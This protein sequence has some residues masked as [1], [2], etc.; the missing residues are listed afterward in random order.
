MGAIYLAEAF[1]PVPGKDPRGPGGRVSVPAPVDPETPTAPWWYDRIARQ[2]KSLADTGFTAVLLP[3]APKTQSGNKPTGSGYGLLD[4][5]DLGSKF[6]AG[7]LETRFGSKERL[8]R[9]IATARGNG[10]PAYGNLAIHQ[11]A[12]GKAGVYQYPNWAGINETGRFPKQPGCFRSGGPDQPVPPWRPQ[13]PVP[14]PGDDFNFG[15]EVSYVNSLPPRYMIEGTLDW[16]EWFVKTTGFEG[17]RIDD[18]KGLNP[19]A[20]MEFLTTPVI[21]DLWC[22]GEFFDGNPDTLWWYVNTVM[23]RRMSTLDFGMHWSIKDVL[24]YGHGMRR[25]L[26]SAYADRDPYK[27]VTFVDDPDTDLSPGQQIIGSKLLGYARM[28]F[29]EG[30]PL[31]YHRDYSTD[32]GC[33]GLKPQ[34]DN[35]VWI[36][37]NLVHGTKVVRWADDNV[38]AIERLGPPGCIGA[39]S[40][41][42]WNHRT[43]TVGTE[44]GAHRPLH[45]YTGR[46]PDIWTDS[47]GRATFTLPSNYFGDGRSYLAFG[48][49][50]RELP[51]IKLWPRSTTQTF[52]GAGDL[53]IAPAMNSTKPIGIGRIWSGKGKPIIGE[54]RVDP[55]AA[56][57]AKLYLTIN[58]PDESLLTTVEIVPGTPTPITGPYSNEQAAPQ[59]GWYRFGLYGGG[60]PDGG[61]PFE[62]EV[63]YT[64]PQELS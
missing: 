22:F 3:P 48:P 39:I 61:A 64:A 19:G 46:H 50:Q 37:Q 44:F 36:H 15:D 56:P 31:I 49:P 32:H 21:R 58:A 51:V 24:D 28:F 6:Q 63:T 40:L 60:L 18:T 34:I 16:L 14:A 23:K 33:Y 42:P 55:V 29:E 45:D 25:W 62:L 1:F 7:S 8:Q 30:Q 43:I 10:M 47:H 11:M 27:A 57:A 13:D 12:G 2:C 26:N 52:F 59:E 41:D 35:L 17:F 54:M 38:L 5:F 20:L 53:D 4:H 9:C